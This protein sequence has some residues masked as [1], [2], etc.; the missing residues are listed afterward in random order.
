MIPRQPVLRALVAVCG[1]LLLPTAASAGGDAE[2]KKKQNRDDCTA[3][4]SGPT[5]LPRPVSPWAHEEVTCRECHIGYQFDR[6]E[7]VA[8]PE[9]EAIDSFA[10]RKMRNPV[11][12]AACLDCHDLYKRKE[13]GVPRTAAI[14]HGE[15]KDGMAP[16]LPLCQDCHGP[17][18]LIRWESKLPDV[19]RRRAMNRRCGSCH[20][21]GARMAAGATGVDDPGNRK[22]AAI[23]VDAPGGHGSHAHGPGEVTRTGM[24]GGYADSIHGRKLRLGVDD[25]PGCVDCHGGHETTI[26]DNKQAKSAC[27]ECHTSATAAFS[28]LAIHK[29]M[30]REARPVAFYTQQFFG[31]LTFL[32]ILMLALHVMLDVLATLRRAFA[33]R[34]ADAPA[35]SAGAGH[36]G[37]AEADGHGEDDGHVQRFDVHQRISHGLMLV[38]FVTLV[39]TGWPLTTHSLTASQGL[40]DLFGG[41]EG[42][43]LVHRIAA[44]VMVLSAAHH[45]GYLLVMAVRGKLRFSMMPLPRDVRDLFHNLMFFFGLRDKRPRYGRYSYFE[46]FDYWAVFWG[47]VIMVGS[48]TIR[49]FPEWMAANAPVWLYE[50]AYLA[51]TDEALLAAMA[52]FLWHF[53]NVHLRPAVFPMSWVFLDGRMSYHE[54]RE[55]H[56][57][58]YDELVRSGDIPPDDGGDEAGGQGGAA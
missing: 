18:H 55:D 37:P 5:Y 33:R 15:H 44:V 52:I 48:G 29:P 1:L 45:I 4:H 25:A 9:H 30:T 13:R 32:T 36:G 51:H 24:L 3:C 47:V 38:S 7:E 35:A 2:A 49:W 54:L 50:I 19:E 43:A 40:M 58:E 39:L 12:M 22:F 53:Y 14:P 42:C 21:D 6:N 41:P 17:P 27:M 11:A 28:G 16:G 26:P 46:K 34:P 23:D 8:D 10:A 57:D 56:A 20:A 31:W